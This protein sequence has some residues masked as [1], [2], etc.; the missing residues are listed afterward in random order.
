MLTGSA[1]YAV[2]DEVSYH[3]MNQ[4]AKDHLVSF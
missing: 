2:F 3:P 4:H 1:I